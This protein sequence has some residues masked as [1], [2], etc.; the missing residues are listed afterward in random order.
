L[1]SGDVGYKIKDF[2]EKYGNAIRTAP[3]ELTFT[4]AAAVRG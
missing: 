2:H 3:D 4:S 1:I